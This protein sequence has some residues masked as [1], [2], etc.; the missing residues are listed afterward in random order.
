MDQ[1]NGAVID[2]RLVHIEYAKTSRPPQR[3]RSHTGGGFRRG[4]GYQQMAAV[5]ASYCIVPPGYTY[6][7]T[8]AYVDGPYPYPYVEQAAAP[9]FPSTVP[10]GQNPYPNQEYSPYYYYADE[11]YY[12]ANGNYFQYAS[13]DASDGAVWNQVGGGDTVGQ[14]ND[15][16]GNQSGSSTSAQDSAKPIDST[17]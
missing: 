9:Y 8:G 4:S 7:P 13:E 16:Q 12:D 17:T 15:D 6:T 14:E 1:M 5:P 2:G 10:T 11:G 3:P